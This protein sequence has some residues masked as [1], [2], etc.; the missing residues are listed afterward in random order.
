MG[1]SGQ[2]VLD[3]R[4]ASNGS[5]AAL[6]NDANVDVLA[7]LTDSAVLKCWGDGMLWEFGV[8]NYY[9]F[10]E[11]MTLS[12]ALDANCPSS[13]SRG[14]PYSTIM[15]VKGANAA[16]KTTVLRA[17]SFIAAFAC[18]SFAYDPASPIPVM[19]HFDSGEPIELFADF[20]WDGVRYLY[21]V[22]MT[23]REVRREAIS[24]KVKKTT[25]LVERIGDKLTHCIREFEALSSMRLRTNVS[26]VS[27]ARQYGH[28]E[29]KPIFDFFATVRGN[30][31]FMGHVYDHDVKDVA[32]ELYKDPEKRQFVTQFI[33]TADV[34]VTGINIREYTD[35]DELDP[36]K[37]TKRYV[38]FFV[39]GSSNKFITWHT[40]SSGT[41]ALFS[42]LPRFQQVL[43]R[44][45]V[46]LADEFDLHLHPHI[47]PK[48]LDLFTDP[49]INTSG[50]QL[51][52]TT[53]DEAV[54]EIAGKYRTY[55][56]NKD[57]NESF[58]YR[59]DE[60]AGDLVRN[61]RPVGPIYRAGK[62]GGVPRL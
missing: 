3:P 57:D 5:D 30:V 46:L 53:H 18:R 6:P 55:I 44:G 58:A 24:R 62:L 47:I 23:D 26:F 7:N 42:R 37:V 35:K 10:R 15:C 33:K 41:R 21:E 32:E 19:A 11:G 14:M 29:V 39:H 2:W 25:L 61:D 22:T 45:G 59:L 12:F 51:I 17:M 49:E 54:L 28:T 16:G 1:A 20:E 52:F 31:S 34:G 9:G 36:S 50:A 48:L 27:L 8:R 56:V 43:R 40:E 13:I 38:P 4:L 60:I